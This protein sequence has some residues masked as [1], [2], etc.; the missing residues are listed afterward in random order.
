MGYRNCSL[1]SILKRVV[2]TDE[3]LKVLD[4]IPSLDLLEAR[5]VTAP[6]K[7]FSRYAVAW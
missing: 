7:H 6:I 3:K 5:T 4:L 1:L 2:Y